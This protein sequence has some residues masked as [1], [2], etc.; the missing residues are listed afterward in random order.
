MNIQ[1]SV[2]YSSVCAVTYVLFQ[3]LLLIGTK[4]IHVFVHYYH[5]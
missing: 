4:L 3:P 1:A 5:W 2:H